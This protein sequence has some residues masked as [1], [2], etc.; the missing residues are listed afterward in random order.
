MIGWHDNTATASYT[1]LV[2]G[3][4]FANGQF[5]IYEDGAS[6]GA[7]GIFYTVGTWYDIKIELKATGAKYYYKPITS[8]TWQEL[9]DSVY[10]VESNL[11]PGLSHLDATQYTYVDNW[12]IRKYADPVPMYL[13][14]AET[15]RS[16]DMSVV[17]PDKPFTGFLNM[18]VYNWTGSGWNWL[19]TVVDNVSQTV[20]VDGLQL[21]PIWLAN[22][23]WNTTSN[24][25]GWYHIRGEVTS[26]TG[27]VLLSSDGSPINATYNFSIDRYPDINL[28]EL[29]PNVPS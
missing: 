9:Y 23:A 28:V 10:S 15:S 8:D 26:P 19:A 16:A 13:I 2:Y 3:I 27:V 24:P 7:T 4:Y 6:R 29:I 25:D 18:E 14:G 11:R 20:P 1:S 12:L 17:I 21:N 5:Y 22:G